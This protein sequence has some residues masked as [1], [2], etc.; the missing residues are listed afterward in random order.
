MRMRRTILLAT[1]GLLVFAGSAQAATNTRCRW[2][3][4]A[5]A[6]KEMRRELHLGCKLAW[7]VAHWDVRTGGTRGARATDCRYVRHGRVICVVQDRDVTVLKPGSTTLGQGSFYIA[8]RWS[9][10]LGIVFRG[11][12]AEAHSVYWDSVPWTSFRWVNY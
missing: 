7:I 5:P 8:R 11:K 2:Q 9:Y 10:R 3:A 12:D 1:L 6:S 4:V